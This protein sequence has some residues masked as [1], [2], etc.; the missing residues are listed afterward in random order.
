MQVMNI[1]ISGT[2]VN[3]GNVGKG[4]MN[5]ISGVAKGAKV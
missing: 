1:N 3:M 2:K 5:K 4:A